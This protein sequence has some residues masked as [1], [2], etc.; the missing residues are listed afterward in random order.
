MSS[1]LPKPN[2][3][4]SPQSGI[5]RKALVASGTKY[6]LATVR[7]D[8]LEHCESLRDTEVPFGA[9]RE[10]PQGRCDLYSSCDVALIMAIMGESPLETLSSA[11][12]AEW[13]GFIN[14]FVATGNPPDGSYT[15]RMGQS[16]LH[17]NGMVIGALGVLGG[18]MPHP[19]SLYEAFDRPEKVGPWLDS[20]DWNHAW[21][22]SHAFWGGIH[23]FSMSGCASDEWL[24]A[25]F[26]WLDANMDQSGWW[27]AGTPHADGN[28]GLGGAAHL[29]PLYEHHNR[30]FPEPE[31]MIDSVLEMQLPDGSWLGVTYRQDPVH[32]MNYLDLDA[33]YALVLMGKYAPGYRQDDI[34]ASARRYGELAKAYYRDHRAALFSLHPHFVLSA[35]GTFGLL[36]QL[37]PDEFVDDRA[38]TDIFSD[39]QLYRTREVGALPSHLRQ[40]GDS[41]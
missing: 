26:E 39:R 10:A 7:C 30:R 28:Q 34:I 12:R 20:L 2:A 22:Q 18:Q 29:F 1:P 37:L 38:W 19:V 8:V 21:P 13:I 16:L 17:A 23:C 25:V 11:Q 6:S 40:S 41:R 24:A 4:H 9:Y 36:Q 14:S 27:R 31:R 5:R 32:V 3:G 33:L 35:V 15:D